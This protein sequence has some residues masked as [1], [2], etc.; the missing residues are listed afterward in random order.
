[1]AYKPRALRKARRRVRRLE[2][3]IERMD[4]KSKPKAPAYNPLAPLTGKREAKERQAAT[5]LRFGD[6]ERE[7]NRS[8]ANQAQTQA[9]RAT[10]YDDYRQALRE[11]TARVN[12]TN[13]Q[14]VEAQE[15][16][17]DKAQA[18]DA[19]GVAAR[20]AAASE[21]AAKL[22]RAPVRSEEGARAVAAQRTMGNSDVARLR[23]R[24]SADNKYLNLRTANSAL[25]KIEDQERQSARGRQISEKQRELAKDKG[26]FKTKHRMDTRESERQWSAIKKE[27][28]LKERELDQESRASGKDRRLEMAKL[29]TQRAVARIYASGD[30]ASARAQIKVAR[31]NLKKGRISQKQY[32]YI[33]NEYKGLPK[34]GT[35]PA[36]KDSPNGAGSGPGGS[37][38]PWERDK[39]TNAVRVLD[40]NNAKPRDRRTWMKR[41]QDE[42]VPARLAARAWRRYVKSHQT[43]DRPGNAPGGGGRGQRPT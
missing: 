25:A 2:N 43:I 17:V 1:M 41:M 22:G 16:R 39:I 7:L 27:F 31:L 20:D 3:R 4:Q 26:A 24:E 15:G 19:A 36:A 37:L 13:R 14:N 38:A 9:D 40:K 5:R 12:E 35:P 32:R 34:K 28:G 23:E 10:Y 11:A 21:Q 42:G 6:E 8:A 18:E 29:R 30:R 33:L